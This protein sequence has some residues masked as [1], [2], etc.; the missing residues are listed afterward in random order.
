MR[1][2]T[3]NTPAPLLTWKKGKRNVA[4]WTYEIVIGHLEDRVEEQKVAQGLM[5]KINRIWDQQEEIEPDYEMHRRSGS[6]EI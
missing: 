6:L 3:Y 4:F 1:G 5:Y 2:A